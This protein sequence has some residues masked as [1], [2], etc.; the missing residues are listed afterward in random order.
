MIRWK[1]IGGRW[2]GWHR[3]T[4]ADWLALGGRPGITAE[5]RAVVAVDDFELEDFT[6]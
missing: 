1:T 4:P 5:Y 3:G 6:Q 2:S